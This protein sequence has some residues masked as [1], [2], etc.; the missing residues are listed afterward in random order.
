[1]AVFDVGDFAAAV[2]A[3]QHAAK[4]VNTP[5]RVVAGPG[6]G[7]SKTILQRIEHL[8]NSGVAP[9]EIYV[10][11]FT[12]ASAAD[13]HG[14]VIDHFNNLGMQVAGGAVAANVTTMHALALRL[15]GNAN[16]L[17]QLFP[18]PPT[19]LDRW[20]QQQI[21][22]VEFAQEANVTPT[23]AQD[24]RVAFDAHWQT[25]QAL[26]LIGG[27]PPTAAEQAAFTA[28]YP[29]AKNLYACVLP[30]EVVRVCV[31][32]IAG[33]AIT[34]QHIPTMAHLIVDEFQDLNRCDQDFVD[35][36]ANFG[37]QLF[38]AG[39]DDQSIYAFRHAEPSGIMNFTSAHGGSAHQLEHCFRCATQIL[40]AAQALI[41]HGPARIQKNY[42]SMYQNSTPS[43]AGHFEV[44]DCP[45]GVE[46]AQWIASSC[47]DLIAAGIDP[48]EI[49]VLIR[50]TRSQAPLL[51][52]A[53]TAAGVPFE[54]PRADSLLDGHMP[55][56]VH[57]VLEIVKDPV[58]NYV[59][60][61][62][63]LGLKYGV[64]DATRKQI[65]DQVTAANLNFR[66][67]FHNPLPAGLFSS[68]QAAAIGAVSGVV[69]QVASWGMADTLASR[70]AA[71]V[72]IGQAIL[73]SNS[74]PGQLALAEWGTLVNSLPGGM[75]LEEF[76]SFLNSD[77]EAGRFKILD[78]V[79]RRLG[80]QGNPI[81]HTSRVR[82]LTM[83]GAK[84]LE[85]QIVFI[86][87]L[88][89]GITPS[90][91]SIA[92]AGLVNE[93]R[94]LLYTAITRAKAACIMSFAR[95]RTGN[96]AYLLGANGYSI[97]TRSR[98]VTQSGVPSQPRN[99]GLDAA[100]TAAFVATVGNL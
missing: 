78:A 31:D 87:G 39:D 18:V 75:T 67:L 33:G 61:R 99:S 52:E 91:H 9:G 12:R 13:L 6:S 50:A 94:R 69:Q 49:L 7:K 90:A 88:E 23:R 30:G 42:L 10:I 16:L 65:T 41:S 70:A 43:V 93:E 28:Y 59:A 81:G 96:Q 38:I 25:L 89:E 66:D 97:R 62:V 72:L 76:Y 53:L 24:I 40:D 71:L 15:L 32:E 74:V 27:T 44:W 98:F 36:L 95:V 51:V 54:P 8:L 77:T 68:R 60:Y 55:R 5:I 82:M 35:Q 20:R 64:G 63:I 57:S 37:A 73:N 22:D 85:G 86:P 79:S 3:Q 84:G 45:T 100:S 26:S 14:R 48:K 47:S 92:A 46:E 4:E 80:N 34:Q 17:A 58:G 21:F 19:I 29:N 1:M 56:L 2:Q 83:H 11:S